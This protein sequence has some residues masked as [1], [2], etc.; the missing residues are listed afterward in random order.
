[1]MAIFMELVI[2]LVVILGFCLLAKFVEFLYD[3]FKK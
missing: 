3:W 1:M 2:A